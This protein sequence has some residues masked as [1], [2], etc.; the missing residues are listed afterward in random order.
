MK[1]KRLSKFVAVATLTTLI[2]SYAGPVADVYAASSGETIVAVN[3]SSTAAASSQMQ[4]SGTKIELE[5]VGDRKVS[6]NKNVFSFKKYISNI[7]SNLQPT[8]L[9]A[10]SGDTITVYVKANGASYLPT[11]VFSQQEAYRYDYTKNYELKEGIN[12]ITVPTFNQN[13]NYDYK[14]TGGGMI[15]IYNPY[16]VEQQG[17]TPEIWIDGADQVPY[18]TKEKDS[19][20]FK[21]FLEEYKAK[22]DADVKAHPNVEDR[23]VLDIFEIVSDHVIYTGSATAAYNSY[24]KGGKDPLATIEGYDAWM[25]QIFKIHGFD[26]SDPIHDPTYIRESIR[27]MQPFGYMYA[28]GDHTGIQRGTEGLMLGD[29]RVSPPGWGLNH[30][31]GHRIDILARMWPEVTNNM[32]AMKMSINEHSMDNRIPYETIYK[33]VIAENKKSFGSKGYFEQLGALWQL[34]IAYPGYWANLEKLYREKNVPEGTD[35]YKVQMLIKLSSDAVKKD[36]SSHFARHGFAVTDETRAYTN[37]YEDTKNIWYLNNSVIGHEKDGFMGTASVKAEVVTNAANKTKTF[38][39]S[40]DEENQKNLLGYEIIRDDQVIGFTATSRFVDSNI[41]PNKNYAYKVVAY[42]KEL[43][44]LPAVSVSAFTPTLSVEDQVTLKLHQEFNPLD[45]VKAIDHCGADITK[46]ITFKSDVKTDQKGEY[47]VV[48]T[49]ENQGITVTK[50]MQVQVISNFDYLSEIQV[51]YAKVDWG[52]FGQNRAP[53]GGTITLLRDGVDVTYAKGLGT[54]ANSTVIYNVEGKGYDHFESYIGIDQAMKGR[55]SSAT[56]EVWVDDKREYVSS[57]FGSDTWSEYIKVPI[58][59][60]SQVKLV[61]TN[62]GNGN[63]SDHSVWADAK[64]TY[65]N[66]VS[67]EKVIEAPVDETQVIKIADGKLEQA[68]RSTLNIQGDITIG[69]MHKLTTLTATSSQ[70]R[71]LAGL[72]HAK[73]LTSLNISMN[74]IVDLSSLKDL[75]NLKSLTVGS[76]TV[77]L[78]DYTIT[79]SVVEIQNLARNRKGEVVVPTFATLIDYNTFASENLNVKEMA[80]NSEVIKVDLKGKAKG[81]YLLNL[82]YNIDGGMVSM[83]YMINNQ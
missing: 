20:E 70:I 26:K 60:A 76:Q 71:S 80:E 61:T 39:L 55:N 4:V 13:S 1:K 44:Q 83:R 41:D 46:N 57:T 34:E 65:N 58:K 17:G 35:T 2:A 62:A 79:D 47:E 37:K 8:G 63:G 29:F 54:H 43:K 33:S 9:A 7:G 52:G 15:Y 50:T 67:V 73:N 48:Y 59:G 40:I 12:T 45:Y 31:I 6:A 82:T 77:D 56:F 3:T 27:L 64:F 19:K 78:D 23:E 68:I 75:K 81:E 49:I 25:E 72:E 66:N 28:S 21:K 10:K 5:Q 18:M 53:Q 11:L 30:E 69:Q 22:I 16:T 32:T 38:I 14:V 74:Q 36:L 42:D 51:A 24:V